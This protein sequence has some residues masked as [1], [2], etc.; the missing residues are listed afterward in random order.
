MFAAVATQNCIRH[1]EAMTKIAWKNPALVFLALTST[2]LLAGI[3]HTPVD[4]DS[5]R[6]ERWRSDYKRP[7][8][9]PYPDSNP[10]TEAKENLGRAL[11]FD[12]RISGSQT[13][14]CASC[15]VPNL[16][17]TDGLAIAQGEGASIMKLRSPSLVNIAWLSRLGWDG[18][19][20][21]I[22][23]VTFGPILAPSNTNMTE[24]RLIDRLSSAP[25]YVALFSDAFADKQINR[26]NIELALATYERSIVSKTS[27]FDRWVDGNNS[28]IG[29]AAKRGF[30]LFVGKAKCAECHSGWA[31]TDGSFH[32]IGFAKDGEVGRGRYFPTSVKL[33]FAFKTPTLRDVAHRGPYMHDG[34]VATLED[35]IEFY[36]KGGV[37]RP[38]RAETIKPLGLVAQEKTDLLAFLQ[39]LND[40]EQPIRS[41]GVVPRAAYRND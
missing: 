22:E 33:K 17:W 24:Q 6:V 12:P 2:F 7:T 34:S 32:D 27:S 8:T 38:S 30:A 3:S 4:A 18:K 5:L 29:S 35:V 36:N 37:D 11:F 41:A 1:D 13:H 20:R 31:F 39:S 23:A 14:A 40:E 19:F 26:R 25:S 21:D 16:S 9:I 15:H 28:A 10:Y